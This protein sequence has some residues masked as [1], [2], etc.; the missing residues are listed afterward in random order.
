MPFAGKLFNFFVYSNLFI[1]GCAVLMA[2]QTCLLLHLEP[3]NYL[4]LF[5]FSATICSYSF[6]WYLSTP[7]V[8]SSPRIEWQH[9]HHEMHLVLLIAGLGCSVFFAFYLLTHWIWLAFASAITFLYSAPKIP[10]PYFRALRKVALGKTIF[11]AMVWTFV[12]TVLPVIVNGAKW[13]GDTTLFVISRFFLIYSICILFDYRDREDDKLNGIRSL[14]TRLNEKGIRNLFNF[15][16]AV[17]IVSTIGM[18]FYHHP[19]SR[20]IVLLIPGI[21]TASLFNYARKNFSDMLYYFALDGL[22]ALSALLMLV[23]RI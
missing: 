9:G 22:M 10:H 20:I 7:S 13:Q 5:I 8:L 19:L 12:T 1:A 23:T 4:L 2:Y 3:D 21:I 14:V 6:H 18:L 11:L 15:S 16:I 17:F